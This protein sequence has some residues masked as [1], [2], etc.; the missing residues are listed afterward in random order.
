MKSVHSRLLGAC[1]G[2]SC[3]LASS[4]RVAVSS[5]TIGVTS[6]RSVLFCTLPPAAGE[7]DGGRRPAD[8]RGAGLAGKN[9]PLVGGQHRP[10]PAETGQTD[11]FTPLMLKRPLRCTFRGEVAQSLVARQVNRKRWPRKSLCFTRTPY[12]QNQTSVDAELHGVV[13]DDNSHRLQPL[14]FDDVHLVSSFHIV[15]FTSTS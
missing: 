7:L 10:C 6:T 14:Q 13:V 11:F 2:S 1:C 5:S 15:P 8:A 4:A 12:T 3:C 9:A